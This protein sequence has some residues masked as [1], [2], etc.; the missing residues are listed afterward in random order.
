MQRFCNVW[1]SLEEDEAYD[2]IQLMA[3][4]GRD[5]TRV[6][7]RIAPDRYQKLKGAPRPSEAAD[8]SRCKPSYRSTHADC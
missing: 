6:R 3:D 8:E 5:P 7:F 1:K 4:G 2:L